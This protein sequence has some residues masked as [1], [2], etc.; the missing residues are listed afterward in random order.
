MPVVT[1]E[2]RSLP[3]SNLEKVIYP[4]GT[5]K[6]EVLHHYAAHGDVLLPHL[7][8]RP[9]SLLRYPDGPG[10]ER[11]FTKN[12]PPGA[13]DWVTVCDV[14]RSG[15]GA[16]RQVVVND[17]PAL[18]WVANL[19][20]ELHTPQWRAGSPGVADR[21]VFDLDPGAP[22]TVVECCAVARWLR[23]RL[24]ADGLTAYPK[25]SG[26]KGLHLLC[27][28]RPAPAADTSAYARALAEEAAA[29]LPGLAIAEMARRLRPGKVFI[30]HSQNAAR[31]TT[32]APYT[33]RAA[34]VPA[35][36]APLTWEEV[37]D[38]T[39]PSQLDIRLPDLPA[40]LRTHGDLLRPLTDRRRARSLPR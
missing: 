24:A 18:M 36:S 11:F 20:V 39:D 22:A 31:K 27:A 1:V 15:G 30:D 33:L 32:A 2:G 13:P 9:L 37:E 5:T 3:L 23:D 12:V 28:V 21:L 40:R 14:P 6:G 35:V 10:G 34:P 17:L 26:G 19:V 29:A 4:D 25:T 8:D 7:R 38:C 16:L